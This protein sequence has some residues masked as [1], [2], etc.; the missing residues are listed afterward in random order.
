VGRGLE[1]YGL[2]AVPSR[3]KIGLSWGAFIIQRSDGIMGTLERK[4][5]SL[6]VMVSR[7][8]LPVEEGCCC[9][10]DARRPS[11]GLPSFWHFC[12]EWKYERSLADTGRSGDTAAWCCDRQTF[13]AVILRF[14]GQLV[15][16][17]PLVPC[18]EPADPIII[19]FL[20][21]MQ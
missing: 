3:R 5:F 1:N 10:R 8:V 16:K 17:M 19:L 11:H 7:V 6:F 4:V 9:G 12:Q 15:L 21:R 20:F 2:H 13:V 18:S 14:A